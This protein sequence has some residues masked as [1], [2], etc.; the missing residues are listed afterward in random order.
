MSSV[1]TT[2]VDSTLKETAGSTA[3]GVVAAAAAAVE[4]VCASDFSEAMILPETLGIC[5][6]VQ[7]AAVLWDCRGPGEVTEG[8]SV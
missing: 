3:A 8:V 2:V 6:N 7:G 1:I 4:A 5:E